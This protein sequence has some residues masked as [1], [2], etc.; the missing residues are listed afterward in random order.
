M[1]YILFAILFAT[2]ATAADIG[3]S[4]T[5]GHPDFFGRIELG[6]VEPPPVIYAKPVVVE[7]A[8]REV[9]VEPIYLR[10]PP[11]HAKNWRHFCARYDACGRP[12]YFV[13]DEWYRNEYAPRYRDEHRELRHEEVRREEY[14]EER[15]EADRREEHREEVR[16]EERHEEHR[17][18]HHDEHHHDDRDHRDHDHN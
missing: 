8:P 17:D 5:I 12:V 10:V 13:K 1:K 15:R 18:E 16:R 3:V 4:I 2:T 6:N 9:V 14:R 11:E 7:R